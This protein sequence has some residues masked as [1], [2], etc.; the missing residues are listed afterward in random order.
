MQLHIAS[1]TE[2]R[3]EEIAWI[4]FDT[5]QGNFV[6]LRGHAPMI[7]TLRPLSI[8]VYRLKS[9]KE[10]TKKNVQGVV[11]ITRSTITLLLT[12]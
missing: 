6:I 8:V 5:T 1:P 11:H 3:E 10:E 2:K 9:G 7:M 12:K 4:E